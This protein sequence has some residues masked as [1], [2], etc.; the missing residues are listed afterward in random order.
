MLDRRHSSREC[1]NP[2]TRDGKYT[3][4][5]FSALT[6]HGSWISAIPAKMTSG[7]K[8]TQ[9]PSFQQGV[10]ES[11][12]QRWEVHNIYILSTYLPWIL[13]LGAPC[14]DDE[15]LHNH[16][17]TRHTSRKNWNP[18][19][20]DG[21]YTTSTFSAPTFHGFWISALPALPR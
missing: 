3:T 9:H 19:A 1:W 5:T 4:S 13:D 10:L 21:K 16:H 2:V 17:N 6:F 15:R 20:R 12:G 11:R 14:Q 8:T 18:V 7:C